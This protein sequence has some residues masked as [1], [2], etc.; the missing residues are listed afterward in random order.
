MRRN[1]HGGQ[2]R[3]GVYHAFTSYSRAKPASAGLIG[4]ACFRARLQGFRHLFHAEAVCR[5]LHKTGQARMVAHHQQTTPSQRR[6]QVT[7]RRLSTAQA[8]SADSS[9]SRCAVSFSSTFLWLALL[10]SAPPRSHAC[11][12]ERAPAACMLATLSEGENNGRAPR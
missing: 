7:I 1:W 10:A 4:Q 12:Q 3:C 8:P 9:A 6:C 5:D 11:N 2:R